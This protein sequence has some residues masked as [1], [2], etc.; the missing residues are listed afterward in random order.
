[1]ENAAYSPSV[2]RLFLIADALGVPGGELLGD[3]A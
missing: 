2:D 1:V 3:D